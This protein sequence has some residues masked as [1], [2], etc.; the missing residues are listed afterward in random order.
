MSFLLSVIVG[1]FAMSVF[2]AIPL[3]GPVGA[4]IICSLFVKDM[5]RSMISGFLSGTISGI[6]AGIVITAIL[7]LIGLASDGWSGSLIGGFIG[8]IIGGGIFISSL[9]FGVLGLIGGAIGSSV[10]VKQ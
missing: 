4:G 3:L 8:S 6:F 7:G 5:K 2:G 1:S 10:V 9:Y